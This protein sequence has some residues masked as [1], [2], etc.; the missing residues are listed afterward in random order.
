MSKNQDNTS[1]ETIIGHA[2]VSDNY[3]PNNN[4]PVAQPIVYSTKMYHNDDNDFI[5]LAENPNN[6]LLRVTN[7]M[8]QLYSLRYSLKCFMICQIISA[9]L[10]ASFN[11]FFF[12][13]KPL[14][15]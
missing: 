6:S 8:N 2:V 7:E 11:P 10:Y 5:S 15:V 14:G 12:L 1:N 4:V 9:C 13:L 3:I